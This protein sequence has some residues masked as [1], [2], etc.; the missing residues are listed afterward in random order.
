MTGPKLCY[1]PR[2]ESLWTS[3]TQTAVAY[4]DLLQAPD[5]ELVVLAELGQE[6]LNARALLRQ[7]TAGE[8]LIFLHEQDVVRD[9]HCDGLAIRR[10]VSVWQ[11]LLV[12]VDVEQL[13]R[14]SREL[15]LEVGKEASLLAL[16]PQEVRLYTKP[17]IGAAKAKRKEVWPPYLV[18]TLSSV[19]HTF[20]RRRRRRRTRESAVCE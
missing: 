20:N 18:A 6:E 2:G 19:D 14:L 15:L 11:D 9:D 8:R 16:Q 7:H 3:P 10:R 5:D 13:V 1:A 17:H 4:H 12:L